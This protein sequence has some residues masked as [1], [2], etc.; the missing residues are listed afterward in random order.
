MIEPTPRLSIK[1]FFSSLRFSRKVPFS[2]STNATL[3]LC[4]VAMVCL[5][6]ADMEIAVTSPWL[7]FERLLMGA[8]TPSYPSFPEL[9]S[10]VMLTVQFAVIGVMAGIV[11]GFFFACFYRWQPVR[12]FCAF[13][14]AIHEL[15]WALLLIAV[16]GLSPLAGLLAIAIP[17]SGI[18]A[19]VFSEM[20]LQADPV[21]EDVLKGKASAVI[22]F[23]YGRLSQMA[24]RMAHYATYR[25]EC[26]LRSSAVLGFVGLPTLGFH[27]ES[28]IKEGHYSEAWLL[29]YVLLVL[30]GTKN[31]WFNRRTWLGLSVLAC[32]FFPFTDG[33][34]LQNI[35]Q[36]V[37]QELMPS[38]LRGAFFGD[39][40]WNGQTGTLFISWFQSLWLGE[41]FPGIVN[42]FVLTMVSL[43][44]TG[45][46]VLVLLPSQSIWFAGKRFANARWI[47]VVG[48]LIVRS[49]PE[50][51]LA[52]IVM[53]LVGPSMLPAIIALA[54]HNGG[55]I[56]HLLERQVDGLTLREDHVGGILL[57]CYEIIPRISTQFMSF[58]LYR[59]EVVMRETAILG[60]LGIP[61]LG[62]YIDSAFE[63]I[64][65]DRALL[66]IL[67][68]AGLNLLIEA[69]SG[70]LQRSLNLE[71]GVECKEGV[72]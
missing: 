33:V 67:F 44:L 3:L 40:S 31:W 65:Y 10:A 9:L 1:A 32:V 5:P 2:P 63:D 66:L 34:S 24:P 54:V 16:I 25:L 52:F 50:V 43:I 4:L 47:G 49:L 27:L 19:K 71:S 28:S 22:G 14:R 60:L 36:F 30:I 7:E 37:T 41:I 48:V 57:F 55:V 45:V 64:R 39:A 70:R 35:G 29:M 13:V 72:F 38:P 61:T 56:S 20:L 46:M 62:F 26:A 21:P 68:A 58:W 42:T 8:V 69:V 17:Y 59:W 11:V 51:V 23:V 12:W 18:F 53:L 15:F 6:Y